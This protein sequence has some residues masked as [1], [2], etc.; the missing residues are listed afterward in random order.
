[1][2]KLKLTIAGMH[3]GSC[4]GN[5]ERAIKKIPG[6]KECRVSAVTNKG[7]VEAEDSA[8]EEEMKKAVAKVGY[9]VVSVERS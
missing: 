7:F 5:I 1:M 8:N 6:V 9:K 2:K 3:C 4:A